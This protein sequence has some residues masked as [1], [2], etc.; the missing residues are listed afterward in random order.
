[1]VLR[2]ITKY[3][4]YSISD[5]IC[6]GYDGMSRKPD[7][8]VATPRLPPEKAAEVRAE[9]E[10]VLGSPLFRASRRCQILLRRIIEQTLAGDVDSLKERALG[11]E[12]F[13]RPADYDTSQDP[14]VRASAAE[15]R[16]KLAQYYQ[17]A[18]HETEIRIEL[19]SGSYLA[20][21][22][23]I[24]EKPAAP[25]PLIPT[26]EAAQVDRNGDRIAR[27]RSC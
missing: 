24:D 22:H 9:L 27:R 4:L 8:Q 15:I 26:S 1:M 16:K 3:V 19:P 25:V 5:S 20:E 10:R 12:V 18:G 14:V 17:E 11:V 2:A 13:G 7:L 23:F 21:F 6:D